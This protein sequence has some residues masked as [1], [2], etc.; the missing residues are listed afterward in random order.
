[1]NIT[2]R[3]SNSD[4]SW[5]FG[6]IVG[7]NLVLGILSFGLLYWLFPEQ[8]HNVIFEQVFLRGLYILP[9]VI[10][11]A[12]LAFFARKANWNPSRRFVTVATF[13]ALLLVLGNATLYVSADYLTFLSY[14]NFAPRQGLVVTDPD[15]VRYSP[16]HNANFDLKSSV[17]NSTEQIDYEYTVPVITAKGF[18]YVSPLTNSGIINVFCNKNPGFMFYDDRKDATEKERVRPIDQPFTIGQDMQWFDNLY[19]NTIQTDFFTE[20]DTP[21]YLVLDLTKPE[22]FTTVI[23]KIKYSWFTLPH[24]AG[25]I[26]V[27]DN[28]KI[29]NLTKEQTLADPRLK[30]Q[31]VYP[32]KL[33]LYY[34]KLENYKAGWGILSTFVRVEGRLEVPELPGENQFPFL[35]RGTDG[36][37]YHMIA[38]K[39]QGSGSGLYRMY[40]V[41][42]STGEGTYHEFSSKEIIYGPD[43]GLKRV[44]NL[45]TWNWYHKDGDSKSGNMVAIEPV[46]IVRPSEPNVLYWKYTVT[47]LGYAGISESV[48]A[49]AANVDTMIEYKERRDLEKWLRG[50]ITGPA[51]SSPATISTATPPPITPNSTGTDTVLASDLASLRKSIEEALGKVRDLE[52]RSGSRN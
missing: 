37:C 36:K 15:F 14:V 45:P 20:F 44:S 31:W 51:V 28:G 41:D 46:Y 18:S 5:S 7:T 43:T 50:G 10:F 13:L 49:P 17:K 42:A 8:F 24:W 19:R 52:R 33:A 29:E 23:P 26:L 21:H 35:V 34:V 39:P 11:G 3:R 38:T 2:G 32:Q 12:G 27:H 9:W 30:G 4:S 22:T 16:L 1:M 48:V 40:Y 25:V 6:S 47:N